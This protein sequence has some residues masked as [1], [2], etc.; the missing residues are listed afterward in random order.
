VGQQCAV[1]KFFHGGFNGLQ[2]KRE[3]T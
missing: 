1:V 2:G 3:H